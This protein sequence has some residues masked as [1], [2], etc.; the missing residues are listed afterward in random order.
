MWAIW[1][2]E[3]ITRAFNRTLNALKFGLG[4][5][6]V[7]TALSLVVGILIVFLLKVFDPSAVSLLNKTNPVLNV[8]PEVAWLMVAVSFLLTGPAEEYIFRG[9][10][11]GG[12]LSFFKNK[13]WLTLAFVSSVFFAVAHLYYALVYGVA[14]LVQFVDLVAF[15][16]AMAATY[17]VSGG[18][19][20]APSLIHG[21]FD[22]TAFVGVATTST[23]GTE[24]QGFMILIG[25]IM[26][27]VIFAER[28]PSKN[29]RQS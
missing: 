21:A 5:F 11:F 26:A 6:G 29:P 9:F 17:Y 16:M 22:A 28:K 4:Y 15:G 18:N 2:W 13:H 27:M 3:F 14:S 10:V 24:L 20:L 1:G 12:L 8:S 19:L 7:L 25:I 23:V